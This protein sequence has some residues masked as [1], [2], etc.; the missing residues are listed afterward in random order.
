MS[1]KKN[2]VKVARPFYESEEER[3]AVEAFS[4]KKAE[5]ARKSLEKVD[6]TKLYNMKS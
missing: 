2:E 6:L 3:L 5:Q 1:G 4:Q